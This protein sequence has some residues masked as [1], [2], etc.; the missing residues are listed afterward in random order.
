MKQKKRLLITGGGTFGHIAPALTLKRHFEKAGYQVQYICAKRDRK[1]PFYKKEKSVKTLSLSGLPRSGKLAQFIFFIKLT[2]AV[3]VAFFHF[4]CFWPRAVLATGGFVTFPYLFWARFFRKKIFLCEQNSFPG[5]VNRLFSS[6]AAQVFTSMPDQSGKLKG[7]IIMSGN[8][9][10]ITLYEKTE[11]AKILKLDYDPGKKYLGVLGGSQGAEA[12]N[13]WILKEQQSLS[14]QGYQIIM[15][16][17]QKSYQEL[18][19]KVSEPAL[20]LFPFIENMGAFYSLCDVFIS[21]SGASSIAEYFHFMK[22]VI[23]VPYPHASDNHQYYNA[24]FALEHL[25]GRLIKESELVKY[26]VLEVL[27]SLKTGMAG[28]KKPFADPLGV[29]FEKVD[30]LFH[31]GG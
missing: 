14:A 30:A 21:R 25:A 6:K 28:G 20:T 8:P 16:V 18:L 19:P 7:K 31:D 13:Q 26:S 4:I 15:S 29:I 10:E 23:F 3:L 17:G 1:F 27:S 22:P 2:K 12:I 11:A 24:R 9:V 5:L